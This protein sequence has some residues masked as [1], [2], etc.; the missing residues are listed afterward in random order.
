MADNPLAG[1]KIGFAGAGNMAEALARGILASGAV[2]ASSIA[3]YDPSPARTGVFLGMGARAVASNAELA[4]LCDAIVLAVKPQAASAAC[5][6][7]RPGLKGKSRLAVSIMA[8]IPIRR[9]EE[10]L[11]GGARVVRAMPNTPMLVRCG[12]TCICFGT[13][14]SEKDAAA[15]EALFA[16][17]STVMRVPETLMDAAT[18]LSG[19]GPAYAFYLVEAMAEAGIAEGFRREDA[20]KLAARAVLG[21]A[22]MIEETGLAP[23]ELRRRVTSPGGTTQAAI[24]RMEAAGV[25]DAISAAVRRAAARAGELAG[26]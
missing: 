24:E 13:G 26:N 25:K 23:E 16:P 1:L 2:Q 17:A 18:A 5:S 3:A 21:A 9:I 20:I 4:E 11:G 22:R 15:A 8:G 12:A 10:M 6:E 14:V 19:S 7:L